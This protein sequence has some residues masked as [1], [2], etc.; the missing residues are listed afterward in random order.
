MIRDNGN[1]ES[2]KIMIIKE[3]PCNNKIELI[4]EEEKHRKELKSS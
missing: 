2:F 4:I 3:F 1:W